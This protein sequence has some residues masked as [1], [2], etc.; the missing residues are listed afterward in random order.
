MTTQSRKVKHQATQPQLSSAWSP[1]AEK[2]A[3]V[4][5]VLEEDQ[6]LVV[7]AK[8]SNRFVQF[9]AQGSFGMRAET[10]SNNFLATSD[11]LNDRQIAA[12]VDAGWTAPTGSPEESTPESQPD[13]SPNFFADFEE[14]VQFSAVARLAVHTLAEVLRVPHPGY[15]AYQAFDEDGA[16]IVLPTL[17]V[18]KR[19]E[20]VSIQKA[21]LDP[22]QLL[23]TTLRDCTG[24]ADLNF[25]GDGDIT[26][27]KG[28]V[29]VFLRLVD[30]SRYV[31][32]L[33]P[34][35][36]DLEE[37]SELFSR[38][39]EINASLG[40]IHLCFRNGTVFAVSS[41][42]CQSFRGRACCSRSGELLPN[43]RRHGQSA[44][45]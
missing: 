42:A 37:T 41:L 31:R 11:Q 4:L 38:L 36:W 33:S 1:F 3:A 16:D 15:L 45:G 22:A 40:H 27:R 19:A 24:L 12:L 21:E 2:L 26:L 35:V 39:N 32:I 28:S 29:G 17:G 14:P 18:K 7:A 6:F 8:R 44:P 9:S 25:N 23:L 30:Q 20:P 5:A 13:G 10:G 34:L 43:R